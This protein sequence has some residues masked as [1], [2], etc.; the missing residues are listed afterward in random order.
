VEGAQQIA[1]TTS[2]GIPGRNYGGCL[3]RDEW[4]SFVLFEVMAMRKIALTALAVGSCLIGNARMDN[5]ASYTVNTQQSTLEIHVYRAGLLK[6]FG[7]DHLISAKQLSGQVQFVQPNI[8]E[9]S[10][11]F[12]V[13]TGSLVVLDPDESEKDRNEVQAT[14]LG[15]QVLHAEQYPQIQF[16]SSRLRSVAQKEGAMEIQMEGTLRLHGVEKFVLVPVR[17][18]VVEGKMSAD[19]DFSLLQSDYGIAPI[20]A[21]GGAVRVKDKLK[22]TFH[23]VSEQRPRP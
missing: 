1:W 18:R 2:T 13:E 5:P 17:V 19:G 8:A 6:A 16:T 9:T 11:N 21:G 10:V 3:M 12:V 15:E 22:I 23:I 14:M 20:R 7:H 4:S